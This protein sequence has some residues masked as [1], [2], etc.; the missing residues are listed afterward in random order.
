MLIYCIF[1]IVVKE[2]EITKL[3][4]VDERKLQEEIDQVWRCRRKEGEKAE[5]NTDK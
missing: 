4:K 2:G 5:R 3:M 1:G